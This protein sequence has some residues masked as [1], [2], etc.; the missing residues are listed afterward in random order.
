[1]GFA[2]PGSTAANVAAPASAAAPRPERAAS[3]PRQPRS[4]PP[5]AGPRPPAAPAPPAAP[6]VPT[7]VFVEH[8]APLPNPFDVPPPNGPLDPGGPGGGGGGGGD[9]L[10]PN[11]EPASMLLIGTGLIGVFGALRR[12]R[13]I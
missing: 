4:A 5:A 11:P 9:D 3:A 8:F 12:R 1:M 13:L 10:S 7:D 2:R 6:P